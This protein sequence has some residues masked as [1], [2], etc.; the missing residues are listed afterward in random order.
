MDD[1]RSR[2]Q[3]FTQTHNFRWPHSQER[4]APQRMASAGLY[5]SPNKDSPDR[6]VCF[7]CHVDLEGWRADDD[8]ISEH[9]KC[10]PTCPYI[11]NVKI[12]TN[13]ASSQYRY[14]ASPASDSLESFLH[15]TFKLFE[16]LFKG[17]DDGTKFISQRQLQQLFYSKGQLYGSSIDRVYHQVDK[18]DNAI[19]SFREF[20]HLMH[21]C[22]HEPSLKD[23]A[24]F[25][26]FP[27]NREVVKKTFSQFERSLF[28]RD[29]QASSGG[30]AKQEATMQQVKDFI[31]RET[32]S[33]MNLPQYEKC[34]SEI[35]APSEFNVT[36]HTEDLIYLLYVLLSQ[37]PNARF[38]G[39]YIED[40]DRKLLGDPKLVASSA[41]ASQPASAPTQ[42]ASA[43]SD[44]CKVADAGFAVLEDDFRRFDTSGD[45]LVDLAE[46]RAQ[47][48]PTLPPDEFLRVQVSSPLRARLNEALVLGPRPEG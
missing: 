13:G 46:I 43:P 14:I 16:I 32:C 21:C 11:P 35:L 29:L 4:F 44:L 42:P 18:D 7:A 9:K 20:L 28:G 40:A 22:W 47:I 48:L 10:S 25:F 8:P 19:L 41:S 23:M 3:S 37:V 30:N 31:A 1:I 26:S 17:M 36:V 24:C 34:V 33:L 27:P 15:E 12:S 6:V 38:D 45:G 5:F 2:V 39:I